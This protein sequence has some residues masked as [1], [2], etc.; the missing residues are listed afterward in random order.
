MHEMKGSANKGH[1]LFE[2]DNALKK[3]MED[4]LIA[5]GYD[6]KSEG[7]NQCSFIRR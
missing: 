4:K 6:S 1:Y 2:C 7:T 5:L 3:A